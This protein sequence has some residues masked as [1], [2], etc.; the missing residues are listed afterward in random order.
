VTS[1]PWLDERDP[2]YWA[3]VVASEPAASESSE[4]P[5]PALDLSRLGEPL[6]PPD[7]LVEDRIARGWLVLLGAKPGVGKTWVAEDLAVAATT[8]RT[9]LGHAIPCRFR[10]LYLD[11]EN[12]EDL[13]LERVHRLGGRPDTIGDRLHYVTESVSLPTGDL[14]RLRATV[15]AFRP[16]LVIVDTL[17]SIAPS[18]ERDTESSAAFL[19]AVWHL[20]R[21]R[22]AAM[23][24]LVH[25]RKSMQGAG[26]D[27]V[28][29]AFRGAGHLV[30]AA[31][32]AWS[33]EPIVTDRPVFLMHDVKA[34]RG[35]K[36]DTVR[37]QVIDDEDDPS[38]TR[39]EVDGI[40]AD[41]ESGYDSFLANVLLYLDATALGE[42]KS[43][44]LMLLP[45]APPKRSATDYL[46]RAVASGVL[47]KP[48]RGI[49]ARSGTPHLDL[50]A[51]AGAA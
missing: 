50:A 43:A 48:R 33:L 20:V 18:A 26:R 10:V 29:D 36:L 21:D 25:L 22:G 6:S 2:G 16:D 4:S 39:V 45:D 30:G 41:V 13:A 46:T 42:A 34:R 8:G 23:L 12:G 9:W 32:R 37:V 40:V 3:A 49:Y 19:A 24:L 27:D 15:E 17:A 7:W 1:S 11:A 28:L 47:L 5:L 31:H 44:D 14:E 38:I 35:R 51:S